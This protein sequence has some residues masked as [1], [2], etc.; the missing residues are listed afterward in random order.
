MQLKK[1]Y[2]ENGKYLEANAQAMI[3]LKQTFNN[4]YLSRVANCDS[5]FV[6]WNTLCSLEKQVSNDVEREPSEDES[7]QACY[8]I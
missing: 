3:T 4:N 1:S 5:V 8:V 2:I 6:V 7:D